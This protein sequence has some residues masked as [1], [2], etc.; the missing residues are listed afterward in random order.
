MSASNIEILNENL[1]KPPKLT[2]ARIMR[3]KLRARNSRAAVF[4]FSCKK[5]MADPATRV[6]EL[7][8]KP[9]SKSQV[10]NYFGLEKKDGELQKETAICR[11]CYR[12]VATK[13][14][15]TSNLLAHLRTTHSNLHLQVK[16]AMVKESLATLG[17][18]TS[19]KRP[20]DQLSLAESVDRVQRY[21]RKG[22]KWKELTDAVMFY[23][24]ETVCLSTLLKSQDLKILCPILTVVMIYL[25][26]HTFQELPFLS[27][28]LK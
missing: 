8:K 7:H 21:E 1:E 4:L 20:A 27:C 16:E 6:P 11:T 22:K 25:A 14:G 23:I 13:N 19:R 15:N 24:A 9:G 10:W 26:D 2:C 12:R 28:M 3:G 17:A 18:S 5:S